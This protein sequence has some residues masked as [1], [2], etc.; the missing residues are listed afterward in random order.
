MGP[1]ILIHSVLF[2]VIYTNVVE[3]SYFYALSQPSYSF[4]VHAS[5]P[6]LYCLFIHLDEGLQQGLL[7]AAILCKDAV[8]WKALL[9]NR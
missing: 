4:C 5:N 6:S 9:S 3:G 2:I 8:G 1:C 7:R